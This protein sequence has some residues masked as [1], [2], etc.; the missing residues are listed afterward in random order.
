MF[1]KKKFFFVLLFTLLLT[2]LLGCYGNCF[3]DSYRTWTDIDIKNVLF[4]IYRNNFPNKTDIEIETFIERFNNEYTNL[5]NNIND[6]I[7]VFVCADLNNVEFIVNNLTTTY[8]YNYSNRLNTTGTTGKNTRYSFNISGNGSFTTIT[9]SNANSST[10]THALYCGTNL[11]TNSS[12][13]TIY[14]N[15]GYTNPETMFNEHFINRVWQ[16]DKLGEQVKI[17]GSNQ[18]LYNM[19]FAR[20]R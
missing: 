16:F 8:F 15:I 2:L 13:N 14:R 10:F 20:T 5:A 19:I 1:N 18:W 17:Y 12:H 6:N 7:N 11:Y 3:A 4:N 9:G